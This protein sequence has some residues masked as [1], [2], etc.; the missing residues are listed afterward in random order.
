MKKNRGLLATLAGDMLETLREDLAGVAKIEGMRPFVDAVG[1]QLPTKKRRRA[2]AAEKQ[3]ASTNDVA[4]A[5]RVAFGGIVQKLNQI[6]DT[7]QRARKRTKT[8]R[9]MGPEKS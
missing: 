4:G 7:A 3:S 2:T 5:A 8:R 1:A 6:V 9:K